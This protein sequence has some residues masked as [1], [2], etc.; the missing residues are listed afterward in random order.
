MVTGLVDCDSS[1]RMTDA[2]EQIHGLV[3]RATVSTDF[4][5]IF[6]SSINWNL[7][8]EERGHRKVLLLEFVLAINT[9]DVRN[10]Q[11]ILLSHTPK[12]TL[13]DL[14][15]DIFDLWGTDFLLSAIRIS[16]SKTR[17]SL[18]TA[19]ISQFSHCM[20]H[21]T[22]STTQFFLSGTQ[23]TP[24]R[25]NQPIPWLNHRLCSVHKFIYTLP[26]M[27]FLRQIIIYT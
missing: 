14:M 10:R 7:M 15:R 1:E 2:E 25:H 21:F 22:P 4:C 26:N 9:A 8:P 19:H 3:G 18:H 17:F 16:P 5:Y 24:T 27:M 6:P 20:R 13:V 12:D 11:V 23:F